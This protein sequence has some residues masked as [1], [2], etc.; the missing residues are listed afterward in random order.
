MVIELQKTA[1]YNIRI[2]PSQLIL[3]HHRVI[4]PTSNMLFLHQK[5][6]GNIISFLYA[7]YYVICHSYRIFVTTNNLRVFVGSWK[8][9]E[10][11]K[12][13]WLRCRMKVWLVALYQARRNWLKRLHTFHI[14]PRK[15][16]WSSLYIPSSMLIHPSWKD[17]KKDFCVVKNETDFSE[18]MYGIS[19]K[20]WNGL[21]RKKCTGFFRKNVP[22]F[23]EKNVP[24]FSVIYIQDDSH[25]SL[26]TNADWLRM[27]HS[28]LPPGFKPQTR[29]ECLLNQGQGKRE[30]GF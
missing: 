27:H 21:F 19:P 9:Q 17:K 28:I 10:K 5:C 26:A 29:K 13:S 25:F 16:E 2:T 30:P 15:Y 23:S 20:K 6:K 1:F 3:T 22:D 8:H 18:K 7:S 24:D 12:R 11:H 14:P 4:V